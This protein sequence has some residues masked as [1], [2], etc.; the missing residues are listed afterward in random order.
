[1]IR[2][3]RHVDVWQLVDLLVAAQARSIYAGRCDVDQ[4]VARKTLAAMIQR[5]G[6]THEG[7]TCVFV[8]ENDKQEVCGFCVGALDRVYHIGDKLV[9]QDV[10]LVV[11]PIAPRGARNALIDAYV[12]WAAGNPA[13][14]EIN[15]SWTDVVPGTGERMGAVYQRKGFTRCGA[16]YRRDTAPAEGAAE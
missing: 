11:E 3:A 9:A 8:A 14:I 13:V 10:F 12:E 4:L 2:A 5:H 16:I 15:L 1:M 6:G 7:G